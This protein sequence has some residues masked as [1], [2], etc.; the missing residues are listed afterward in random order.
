MLA[1]M[2]LTSQRSPVLVQELA[3]PHML[4]K[5]EQVPGTP[6][7]LVAVSGVPTQSPWCHLHLFLHA[8]IRCPSS[9]TLL[10][11]SSRDEPLNS[12]PAC[13]GAYAPLQ[14]REE[15]APRS[16]GSSRARLWAVQ[17]SWPVP[18]RAW[19]AHLSFACHKCALALSINGT[20]PVPCIQGIDGAISMPIWL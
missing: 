18:G 2:F 16:G 13:P 8:L 10:P 11:P 1:L 20:A 4:R 19:L 6:P 7:V 15:A 12:C 3:M 14:E 9:V 17:V 5:T